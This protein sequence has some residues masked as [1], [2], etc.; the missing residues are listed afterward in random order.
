MIRYIGDSDNTAR[1]SRNIK[2]SFTNQDWFRRFSAETWNWKIIRKI[3]SNSKT[4][5]VSCK[6]IFRLK[7]RQYDRSPKPC[8]RNF[9][10]RC[11][12]ILLSLAVAASALPFSHGTS[13]EHVISFLPLLMLGMLYKRISTQIYSQ[14]FSRMK[15]TFHIRLKIGPINYLNIFFIYET[16]HL[17]LLIKSA[18]KFPNLLPSSR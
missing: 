6:R 4:S 14:R 18:M 13:R 9:D 5:T 11:L 12:N 8:S 16:G 3:S 1:D 10:G 15:L 2:F 17:P 7:K